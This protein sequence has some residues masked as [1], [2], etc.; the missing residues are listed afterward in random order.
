MAGPFGGD[1]LRAVLE[2][3]WAGQRVAN[4]LGFT[5]LF[6]WADEAILALGDALVAWV[7][8][9]LKAQASNQ[10]GYV[11]WV[12]TDLSS[13]GHPSIVVP[14][15]SQGTLTSPSMPNNV[16]AVISEHTAFSGRSFRGRIYHVGLT[17][18]QCVNSQLSP[19]VDTD[20]LAAYNPLLS[21]AVAAAGTLAILS[22][23]F[24][25]SIRPT[26]VS[27]PVTHLTMDTTL[28]S[29]RRR[30]PGRGA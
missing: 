16:T 9:H 10:V 1:A 11:Q 23:Q 18:S 14:Q 17:E 20:L 30:L 8:D 4:V 12:L 25:G 24:G 13:A 15:V 22:R 28:D 21:G 29:Q 5:H 26:L 19:G 3:T 7:N 2:M 27:T 6:G